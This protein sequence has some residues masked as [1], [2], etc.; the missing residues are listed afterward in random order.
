MIDVFSFVT[1]QQSI[2]Q[3]A[4]TKIVV[5]FYDDQCRCNILATNW[6]L[7]KPIKKCIYVFRYQKED[8]KIE[9][10]RQEREMKHNE[11]KAERK[12]KYDEIRKKYGKLNLETLSV[13]LLLVGKELFAGSHIPV[14]FW[15]RVVC[16]LN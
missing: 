2:T 11:R 7:C 5:C 14:D 12:Q 4:C 8:E 16:Q 1:W 6:D 13:I 3:P 15:S 10:E 9:R